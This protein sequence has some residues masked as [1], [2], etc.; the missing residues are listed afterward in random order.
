MADEPLLRVRRNNQQR[1]S[2]TEAKLVYIGRRHMVVK[3][4][5]IIPGKKDCG[6]SPIRP[7]HDGVNLLH[8]PAFAQARAV[9]G[10]LARLP[11]D[12]PTYGRQ[13][14]A[15]RILHKL[16]LRYDIRAPQGAVADVFN[17]I[18][19]RPVV[20]RLTE[21]WSIIFPAHPRALQTIDDGLEIETRLLLRDN[22]IAVHHADGGRIVSVASPSAIRGVVQIADGAA[23]L[24]GQTVEVVGETGSVERGEHPVRQHK[25]VRVGEIIGD[26]FLMH[27]CVRQ[28]V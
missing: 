26:I 25:L 6:R 5:K 19:R 17:C 7:L 11:A 13:V 21:A 3:A 27:L 10:V 2:R 28:Q 24:S 23:G 4:S 8:R 9:G 15:L 12:N 18:Q 22:A 1:H 20:T 16:R 14:P